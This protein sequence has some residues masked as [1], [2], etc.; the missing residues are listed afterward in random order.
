MA[1]K[2]TQKEGEEVATEII[3]AAVVAIAEG[4]RKLRQG[5][6]N[7][8]ALVLLIAKASPTFG[9]RYHKEHVTKLHVRAVLKGMEDLEK[10][11]L[12]PARKV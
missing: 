7:D 11:W 8:D 6:L 5:R 1:V 12:K 3:A 4:V 2:V 9:T 10:A